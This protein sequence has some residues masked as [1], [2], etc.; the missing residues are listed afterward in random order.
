M[1]HV[2][3][4]A[5]FLAMVLA[6]G[7]LLAQQP[8]ALE[9]GY[10]LPPKAIIDILDAPPPP[11]A[12]ISPASWTILRQRS[13]CSLVGVGTSSMVNCRPS[14]PNLDIPQMW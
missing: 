8:G 11:T 12:V 5:L 6:P 4:P 2:S 14:F 10:Q 3:L 1:K 13:T 9:T 7:L